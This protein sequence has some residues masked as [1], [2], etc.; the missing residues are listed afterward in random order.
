LIKHLLIEHLLGTWL[1]HG[2]VIN[3]ERKSRE[4]GLARIDGNA[5]VGGGDRGIDLGAT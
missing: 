5:S 1:V 3:A 4:N 2:D